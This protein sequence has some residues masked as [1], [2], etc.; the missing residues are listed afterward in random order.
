MD[1][2]DKEA[3]T[4]ALEL[5]KAEPE[6]AEQLESMLKDRSWEEV[7][8]FAA[9]HQQC[10]NLRLKPGEIP[11]CH[12]AVNLAARPGPAPMKVSQP[13]TVFCS[14][15]WTQASPS[16]SQI[17]RRHLRLQLPRPRKSDPAGLRPKQVP[18]STPR[19]LHRGA[20]RTTTGRVH[21][22]LSGASYKIIAARKGRF[23]ALGTPHPTAS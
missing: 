20:V 5:T 17:L 9:Q 15:C 1:E 19:Y 21:M 7:A 4:R 10:K 14:A 16:G 13:R 6:R 8:Q 11:P 23:P 18:Q 3:L 12:G 2:I 22:D